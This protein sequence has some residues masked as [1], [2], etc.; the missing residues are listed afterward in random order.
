MEFICLGSGSSG[1]AYIIKHD[2]ECVLLE[3]GFDF[4]YLSKKFLENNIS[5]SQI[6]AVVVSHK[7][8]DHAKS[9]SKFIQLGIPVY[10]PTSALTE[11]E[12]LLCNVNVVGDKEKYKIAEWLKI[13][14]FATLH[15]VESY[16]YIFYQIDT[17]ESMLFITDTKNFDFPFT[18]YH[19]DY[20]F[21]ECNHIRKQLEKVMQV[22]LD[23]H[24]EG[25]VY[26]YKRQ[27]SYHLSLYGTKLMLKKLKG[28]NEVKAIFLI[29]L[30]KELCNDI[31][32]KEEI[33]KSFKK[34]VYVCY[35]A[36]GIN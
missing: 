9:L 32:V 28:L 13:I 24:K 20:V 35:A 25:E 23:N 1:N 11:N 7:H 29:H 17:K 30:S 21:I 34:K 14:S 10:A 27:A 19:F 3:C 22:A 2:A 15:D 16:G 6:K 36:G 18:Q 33:A 5:L 4:T 8:S 26:K 31:L 12:K